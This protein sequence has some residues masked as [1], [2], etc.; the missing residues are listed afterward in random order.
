VM[1]ICL[2]H[3][4]EKPRAR[5]TESLVKEI[6]KRA[7][8]GVSQRILGKDYGVTHGTIGY[9]VRRQTWAHVS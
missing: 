1:H 3:H 6:R 2:E 8:E 7:A 5:L 4:N 9:L